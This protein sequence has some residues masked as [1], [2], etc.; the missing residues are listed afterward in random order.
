[1]SFYKNKRVLVTGGTGLIGIPLVQRL[2]REGADVHIVAADSLERF[3]MLEE[4]IPEFEFIKG[5]G[6]V[7]YDWLDLED[8]DDC[9]KATIGKDY[10]FQLAGSKGGAGIGRSKAAT[11]LTSHLLINL[12]MLK[13]A[14][15]NNVEKYLLTSTVGVYPPSSSYKENNIWEG[16]PAESDKYSA[17][18]KRISELAAEAFKE[19]YNWEGVTIVRPGSIYGSWDNFDKDTAMVVSALINKF[20]SKEDPLIIQ[21]DGSPIRD[22]TYADDIADGMMLA[23]EKSSNCE[24]FNL[25]IGKGYSIRQLVKEI[26]KYFPEKSYKWEGSVSETLN[27]RVLNIDKARKVLGFNPKVTLSEGIEKTVKWYIENK[28][29]ADNRYNAF[30]QRF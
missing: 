18:A 2:V 22:F 3:W 28:N 14:K 21:G 13:A 12:N 15:K 25:S 16:S 5:E 8:Y 1:M 6:G 11:F 10:V 4:K 7:T 9:E 27:K 30:K 29:I 19:E 17:W 26:S 24:T 20:V 23:M